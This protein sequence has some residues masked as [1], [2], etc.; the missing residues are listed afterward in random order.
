MP[1]TPPT[2]AASQAN[3][4][5]L[6]QF[7]LGSPPAAIAE[8]KSFSL[9]PISMS[10]VSTTHLLSQSNTEEFIPS[11]IKPGKCSASGNFIGASSQLTITTLAQ[12]QTIFAFQIVA[13]VY[14]NTKTYTFTAAGFIAGYKLGPFENNKALEFSVD[15]QITGAYTEVVA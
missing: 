9:D 1:F 14:R 15:I 4:G 10:E 5:Y 11:L 7:L 6:A 8:I 2:T 12:A 3:T 13:P